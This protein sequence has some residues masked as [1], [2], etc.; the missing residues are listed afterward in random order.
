[1]SSAAPAG[2]RQIIKDSTQ[3]LIAAIVAQTAGLLRAFMMPVLF[4]PSQLGVWNLMNVVVGY[5]ANAHLGAL[6][7]MNKAIPLLRGRDQVEQ[8]EAIKDSVFWLNLLLGVL[9]SGTLWVASLLTQASY[10]SGLRIV[11]VVVFLQ[12][13]YMFLFSLLRA[14]NRF[15][16]V[17]Q[18]VSLLSVLSTVLVLLLGFEFADHLLGALTGLAGAYVLVVVYWFWKGHYQFAFRVHLSSIR[19]AITLGVPLIVLAMLDTIFVSVD[20]WVIATNLG[21]TNLGYYALGIM[22]STM[23]GLVPGAIASVLYPRMLERFASKQSSSGAR[24]LLLGPLRA[25]G[26]LMLVLIGVA[27]LGLPLMIQLFLPKY[28]P[29]VPVIQILM[30][31]AF[32]LSLAAIAGNYPVTLNKQKLLITVQIVATLFILVVD[33]VLLR[34]GY[35]IVGIAWGTAAGYFIYGMGYAL[36][37]IYLALEDKTKTV[38]F[39]AQLLI[40]FVVLGLALAAGQLLWEGSTPLEYVLSAA[41]KLLLVV[42]VLLPSLW[43]VNR[44]GQL[45][46]VARIELHAWSAAKTKQDV[47]R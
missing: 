3:Y 38:R 29:S 44:D 23:V 36:V 31:G 40:P 41:C 4:G 25:I 9:A 33:N 18:G 39:L 42:V 43:L 21:E 46:E 24:G 11:A 2:R 26:A 28:L 27:V 30:L 7:G 10:V 37:A 5:G 17:S 19:E 20:R 1:M 12:M 16:L 34:A 45:A 32:F 6:H 47:A 8:V 14:D 13:I 22:A 35:G 15:G